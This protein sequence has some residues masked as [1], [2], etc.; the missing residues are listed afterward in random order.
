MKAPLL[1]AQD[2]ANRYSELEQ[3]E[4]VV[5]AGSQS[6]GAADQGSDIDLYV[7][8]RAEIPVSERARI[9]AEQGEHAEVDNRFWESGDDW[10]DAPS[11][12]RMDVMFRATEW[13]EEQLE[14]VLVRH[15]ASLGY[16]TC[17]WHNV[18]H[19][20]VLYDRQAWFRAL[21]QTT[22]QAYPERLRQAIVAKNHPILRQ[23]ASSYTQQ[24]ESALARKDLVSV[25]HRAAALLAS[26]FDVLF[27][28]NRLP[29][30]GEKRLV[31][32]ALEQCKTPPGMARQVRGLIRAIP[33]GDRV[34]IEQAQ[35]LVQGLD[36]L[37]SADLEQR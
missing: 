34:I 2:V 10:L 20:Q 23:C 1:L 15:E 33:G 24:I 28:L 4:A 7:Y 26:Y 9:A 17:L 16:S 5:I 18:L 32:I 25:N 27:A 11:G 21:Q 36:D 12:L 8:T 19:S 3:V 37:L 13:I 6:T 14:R 22:R 31:E 29:H 35:A 30:P